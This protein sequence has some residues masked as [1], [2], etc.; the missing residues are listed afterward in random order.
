ML[1]A[2][3][4][5]N[6]IGLHCMY[7]LIKYNNAP[8]KKRRQ[9]FSCWRLGYFIQAYNLAPIYRPSKVRSL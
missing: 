9:E 6:P 8:M 2:V 4:F 1:I 3:G 7:R 5:S